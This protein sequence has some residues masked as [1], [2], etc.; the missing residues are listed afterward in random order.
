[1]LVPGVNTSRGEYRDTALFLKELGLSKAYTSIPIRPPA[2]S[3]VKPPIEGDL[4]E[5]YEEFKEVLGTGRVELLNMPEPPPRMISGDP[6]AWLLN[7]TAVHPLRY[8]YAVEALKNRVEDPVGI[9]E[10]L[11]GENLLLKIEYAGAVYPIRNF[12]HKY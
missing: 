11:V 4:I 2:E 6:V 5:A 8:E 10:E 7:T 3:F 12:K 1:M 9:I